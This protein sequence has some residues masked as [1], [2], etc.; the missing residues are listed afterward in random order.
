MAAR[1]TKSRKF[2]TVHSY[3]TSKHR[4]FCNQ[5]NKRSIF[6]RRLYRRNALPSCVAGFL[7]LR[8]CGR[9]VLY[10]F[11]VTSVI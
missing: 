6:Q 9:E 3:L 7:R 10:T 2:S 11:W 5:A 1:C 8:R 4:K